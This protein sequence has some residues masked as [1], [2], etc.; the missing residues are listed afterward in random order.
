[1]YT[2]Q[3]FFMLASHLKSLRAEGLHYLWKTI[4]ALSVI[5]LC[6][7]QKCAPKIF[8]EHY[9]VSSPGTKGAQVL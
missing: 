9:K 5:A 4:C 2:I 1:M 8:G 7:S 3:I 6:V